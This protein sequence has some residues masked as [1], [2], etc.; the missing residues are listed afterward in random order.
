MIFAAFL[1]GITAQACM[2]GDS[3]TR[4][5]AIA[6]IKSFDDGWKNKNAKRVD[7]VLSPSYIYFTQSG[8]TFERKNIVQTAG[9]PDYKL[10]TMYRRHIDIRIEGNTAVLNTVW[11][12]KG[13]YLGSPFDDSQRCSITLIKKNGNVEILSEHCTPIQ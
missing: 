12:G 5:E 8:G 3:I 10:D 13:N 6:A 4:E 7:S 11:Y 1:T 2:Q 9:S